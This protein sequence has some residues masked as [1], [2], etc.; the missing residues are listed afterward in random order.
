MDLPCP[1]F[2]SLEASAAFVDV[3]VVAG[4]EQRQVV[5]VDGAVAVEPFVEVVCLAPAGRP[6][7]ARPYA[8]PVAYDAG[9][10]PG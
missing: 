3:V 6:V 7:A 1:G 8:A 9:P 10:L 4:T 2:V 5:E